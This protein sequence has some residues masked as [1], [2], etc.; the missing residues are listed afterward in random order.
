VYTQDT[1]W[2]L[3]D[4]DILSSDLYNLISNNNL[5]EKSDYVIKPYHEI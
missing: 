2:E 4:I 3:L 5:Y 1:F